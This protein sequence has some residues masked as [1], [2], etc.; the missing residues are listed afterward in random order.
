MKKGGIFNRALNE[1]ISAMGH[2]DVLVVSD[3]GYP[4][5]LKNVIL[6]DLAIA[7]DLPDI[8][9][10]M[11]LLVSD[12]I[13]ERCIV[14]EEQKLYNPPLYKSLSD[15]VDR[16]PI[17]TAPHTDI[18]GK[19]REAAKVIVRTGALQPWGNV[20][21]VSGVDA[22]GYFSKPGVVVPDYYQQRADYE[23]K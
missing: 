10:V 19:W 21:L 11:K 1:A 14:A 23:E 13:Y 16:C 22:P 8:L 20:V 5:P 2:T 15:I 17:E 3:V 6:A 18:M 4:V 7:A 9:T 12:F